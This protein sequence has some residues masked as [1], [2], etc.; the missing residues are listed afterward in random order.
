V[1]SKADGRIH[2]TKG[3]GKNGYR[4]LGYWKI[5]QLEN[6]ATKIKRVGKKGDK[7]FMSKITATGKGQRKKRHPVKRGTENWA[8]GKLGNEIWAGRKK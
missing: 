3:N 8:A 6:L 7:K 5:G 2:G 1:C 4:N